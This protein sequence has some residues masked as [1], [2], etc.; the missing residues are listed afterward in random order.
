MN[1]LYK[2]LKC[3]ALI[4]TMGVGL[5][6]YQHVE[7][8]VITMGSAYYWNQYQLNPSSAGGVKG[9]INLNV[10]YRQQAS[11]ID[12]SAAIQGFTADYGYNEKMGVGINLYREDIGLVEVTRLMAGYA[13]HLS[14]ADNQQLSFGLS[15]GA[16]N[17]QV[18]MDEV[19]GDAG[20]PTIAE[21]N[22]Q[23]IDFDVD[24]GLTYTWKALTLQAVGLHLASYA[25]DENALTIIRKPVVFGSVSYYLLLADAGK[26]SVSLTPKACYRQVDG[27]DGIV[28]AGAQVGF[29][30]DNISFFTMYHSSQNATFGMSFLLKETYGLSGMYTTDAKDYD[31]N[32]GSDYEIA[33]QVLLG[34]K[35]Q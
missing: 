34:R 15:L 8:Q 5:M 24:F 6:G 33:V 20:D 26:N 17:Q 29:M 14:V 10:L 23:G 11:D 12:G 16:L 22:D 30:D 18:D 35:K 27:F 4:L 2:K 19:A 1:T 13:Y 31:G 21:F 28:D 9:N 3:F 32:A 25:D 7:A